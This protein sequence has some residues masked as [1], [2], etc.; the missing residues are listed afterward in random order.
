MALA[1]IFASAQG[2][3]EETPSVQK[4]FVQLSAVGYAEDLNFLG[5]EAQ[6]GRDFSFIKKTTVSAA[7]VAT[8]MVSIPE[9]WDRKQQLFFAGVSGSLRRELTPSL[10]VGL[11]GKFLFPI[12]SQEN[13]IQQENSTEK[14]K[15]ILAGNIFISKKIR[16]RASIEFG[17]ENI[18]RDFSLNKGFDGSGGKGHQ[19]SFGLRIGGKW[20][21]GR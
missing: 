8:Y 11:G 15:S 19:G 18:L 10:S 9:K 3:S 7:A 12:S 21:F 16:Q 2:T 13:K 5:C 17:I 6:V 1:P 4:N 14:L 20:Q